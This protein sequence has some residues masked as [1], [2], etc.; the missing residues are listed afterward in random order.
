MRLKKIIASVLAL[1]TVSTVG[2]MG[3]SAAETIGY[4]TPTE[5]GTYLYGDVDQSGEVRVNDIQLIR[6]AILHID[7]S[8]DGNRIA[9]VSKDGQVRVNDILLIRR[10]LL[11]LDDDLGSFTIY[12]DDVLGGDTLEVIDAIDDITNVDKDTISEISTDLVAILDSYTKMSAEEK[13]ELDCMPLIEAAIENATE[14]ATALQN[15]D[16]DTVDNLAAT[17]S[18]IVS[19]YEE[20]KA[21]GVDKNTLL[22][23]AQIL[24]AD[25]NVTIDAN[26][27]AYLLSVLAQAKAICDANGG[28]ITGEQLLVILNSLKG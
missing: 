10:V 4:S 17:I 7:E 20:L 5:P 6:R 24:L 15:A 11:H 16:A 12:A 21:T 1:A 28:V 13:A 8:M 27:Q 9:D 18:N 25:N 3:V 22:Q 19:V 23:Q 2:A 26:T 14:F